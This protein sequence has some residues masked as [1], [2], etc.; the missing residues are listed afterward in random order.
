MACCENNGR[1]VS[2]NKRKSR[3]FKLTLPAR[4]S[5]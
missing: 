4:S 2:R 5:L 3:R 1:L